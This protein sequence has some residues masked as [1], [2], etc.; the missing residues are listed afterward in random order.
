[1]VAGGR[2]V[3]SALSTAK[4]GPRNIAAAGEDALL[5]KDVDTRVAQA[6]RVGGR[7]GSIEEFEGVV[8]E[9]VAAIAATIADERSGC[10][11]LEDR[12]TEFCW[13]HELQLQR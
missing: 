3:A 11:V 2:A 1:M 4:A 10:E 13:Q 9:V 8:A 6:G 12:T 7:L 5:G